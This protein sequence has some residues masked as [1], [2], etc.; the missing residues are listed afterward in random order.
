MV[1]EMARLELSQGDV[2][3]ML[4]ITQPTVS[5]ILSNE[6]EL[7]ER[8]AEAFVR[9]V[10]RLEAVTRVNAYVEAANTTVR[11]NDGRRRLTAP[12]FVEHL[13]RCVSCMTRAFLTAAE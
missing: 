2:A 13:D 8:N 5:N 11:C 3:Q 10:A 6:H 12:E 1:R 9:G 4:G 7:T